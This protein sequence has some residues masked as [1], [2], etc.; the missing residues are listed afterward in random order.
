MSLPVPNEVFKGVLDMI[1]KYEEAEKMALGLAPAPFLPR[2]AVIKQSPSLTIV[3]TAAP[4]PPAQVQA[5]SVV[6]RT[7]PILRT[8]TCEER[9]AGA[10]AFL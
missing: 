4:N 6:T 10:E 7:C 2:A 3:P 5:P 9:D 1:T 8:P